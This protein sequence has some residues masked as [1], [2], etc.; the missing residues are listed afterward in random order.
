M[1]ASFITR[2]G[3]LLKDDKWVF[4][5]VEPSDGYFVVAVDLAGF[6]SDGTSKT[7]SRL[8]ETA[9]VIAKICRKGWWVKEI[10]HGQ[11]DVRRTALEI[12]Q[13]ARSC[14]AARIGIEKTSLMHAVVPYLNDYMAQ[15]GQFRAIEPL[16]HGNTRKE[17]RISW[18]LE[19]RLERGRII[20]NGQS[21]VSL[22][23]QD[24]WIQKLIDQANDFPSH[25]SHDDLIDA[26]AYVDQLG[27]TIF[28]TSVNPSADEWQPLDIDSGY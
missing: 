26:L 14:D 17:D 18:A 5:P 22:Y 15:F 27:A 21:G 20:L 11:W 12:V 4:D 13:A 3:G 23:E 9:I 24:P 19:G 16:S 2:G 10:V 28:E 1:E 25:L 6:S 7:K 8:D